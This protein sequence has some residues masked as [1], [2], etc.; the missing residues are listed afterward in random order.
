MVKIVLISKGGDVKSKNVQLNELEQLYKKCGFSSSDDFERRHTWEHSD[1]YLSLYAKNDG[2]ARTENKYDC[3]PPCDKPEDLYFG[4]LAVIKHS[5]ET[6]DIDELVNLEK[7]EWETFYEAAFGG[8]ESLG[9]EDSSEDELENVPQEMKT[10]H[11]YLKDG[12]VVDTTSSDEDYVPNQVGEL[13]ESEAS[14]DS[15]SEDDEL[16]EESYVSSDED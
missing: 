5:S 11:G 1:G 13:S 3:P 4:A 14:M 10:K 15:D 12:F 8:F 6:P 16:S 9:D 7:D 2:K